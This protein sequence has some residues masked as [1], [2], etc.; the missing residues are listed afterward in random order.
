[1]TAKLGWFQDNDTGV[2]LALP[3]SPDINP[4]AEFNNIKND[5]YPA[6]VTV[7][8]PFPIGETVLRSGGGVFNLTVEGLHELRNAGE[9]EWFGYQML[10]ALG[11]SGPGE[12]LVN[13]QEW[14]PVLFSSGNCRIIRAAENSLL[15][16]RLSFVMS[17]P[18]ATDL[19][20]GV[21]SGTIQTYD[22]RN[23]KGDYWYASRD[24]KSTRLNSSHIPLSRMP[25]SA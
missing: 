24:R 23:S 16:Y 10:I 7:A 11:R 20:S 22:G 5:S 13:N 4:T 21:S 6:V 9:A 12:L 1:M 2:G 18:N 15:I 19:T 25:S 17:V 14:D 8:N 3:F